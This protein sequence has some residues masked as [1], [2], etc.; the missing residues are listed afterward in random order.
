MSDHFSY[1]SIEE[2]EG[3]EMPFEIKKRLNEMKER[4]SLANSKLRKESFLG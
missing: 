1:F 2:E 3:V 4:A